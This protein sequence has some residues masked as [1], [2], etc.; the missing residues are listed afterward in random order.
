MPRS[1]ALTGWASAY[2]HGVD[3][4]D[5]LDPDTLEPVPVPVCLNSTAGRRDLPGVTYLR[6]KLGPAE[7][8]WLGF[9]VTTPLRA[10]IDGVRRADNLVAA[11]VFLDMVGHALD[12]DIPAL[13]AWCVAHP[14][15]RGVVQVREALRWC[16]PHSASPWE[17]RLGMF[18]RRDAGLLRP[19]VNVPVFTRDGR[20][21]GIPDLL[22]EDAGLVCESTAGTIGNGGSTGTTTSVR[23]VWRAPISSYAGWTASTFATARR[24]G[25]GCAPRTPRA[26]DERR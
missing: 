6:E 19:K 8:T 13:Q 22:D 4:L 2:V 14:G 25:T 24:C 3:Y 10:T 21:V 15:H 9:P 16:D 1:G 17:T 11:V 5:G 18:Y 7:L 23:R 20:F 26:G 12:L